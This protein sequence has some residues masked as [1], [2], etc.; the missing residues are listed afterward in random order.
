MEGTRLLARFQNLARLMKFR[1]YPSSG[2]YW[3][4]NFALEY[5]ATTTPSCRSAIPTRR[6]KTK[7]TRGTG[8]IGFFH[9]K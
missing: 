6:F 8:I 2:D 4:R 9:L 7:P 3:I 5:E 1:S